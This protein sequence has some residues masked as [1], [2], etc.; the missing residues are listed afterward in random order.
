MAGGGGASGI[1]G[2]V[3][4]LMAVLR[5]EKRKPRFSYLTDNDPAGSSRNNAAPVLDTRNGG[6]S[7]QGKPS[8]GQG[9]A[10]Q[11]SPAMTQS[12]GCVGDRDRLS[13]R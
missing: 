5:G 12:R 6:C 2:E 10:R 11:S 3:S 4:S 13:A 1:E 9:T 8:R 7:N